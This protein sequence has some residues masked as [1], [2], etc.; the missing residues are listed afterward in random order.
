M[1][2]VVLGAGRVGG[3]LVE[4]LITE[5][6]AITVVDKNAALLRNLQSKYD[7]R[8]VHGMASHPDILSKAGVNEADLLIAVTAS[9][10]TNMIGC[11][12]SYRL[13]KT[14]KKIARVRSKAYLERDDIFNKDGL[15]VDVC[16]SPEQ[17]V[18]Q[19][20]ERL[21]R[22]PGAMQVLDFANGK[23]QLIGIRA[24]KGGPFCGK[25]LSSIYNTFSDIKMKILA[26]YRDGRVI[27]VRMKTAIESG[28]EI[29][30]ITLPLHVRD[31]INS[32]G[33]LRLPNKKI[34]I[35]GGGNI[36]S[37]LAK[38][39]ES[40]YQVKLI[41]KDLAKASKLSMELHKTIVLL[42][43][44][45]DGGLLQ[46]ENIEN[47]DV[48]VAVTNDDEANILSCLQ[49]KKMGARI[50]MALINRKSYIDLLDS[51]VIDII[52]YPSQITI[53]SI[54]SQIR[55]AD[56]ERVYSLRRGYA[57]AIEVIAH[58]DNKTSAVIGK[59]ISDIELPEGSIVGAI[60]RGDTIL[61]AKKGTVIQTN[62]HLVIFVVEKKHI[63]EI[64]NLFQVNIKYFG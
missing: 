40:E 47:V 45:Q 31:L 30:F 51:K 9:D 41:E 29:F 15:M 7:I 60:Y 24:N 21:M 48:F 36:G 17:L 64:E 42:G 26:I 22:Y 46:Q 39:I 59:T 34:I 61:I 49:A 53:G 52:I 54:L 1:Q 14:P 12:I 6:H 57:E 20:I 32:F 27:P 35:A 3:T 50:T 28:D 37:S 16:I 10:E 43:T 13:F 55:H 33:R 58:G 23:I 11:Q 63:H 4:E 38:L 19:H 56:I 2:I 62:D 44:A 5:D 8:T 18:T 25:V